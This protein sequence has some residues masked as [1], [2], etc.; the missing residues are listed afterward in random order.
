MN[1]CFFQKGL[2]QINFQT[3]KEDFEKMSSN[4]NEI[5]NNV[6]SIN[7]V[8][9]LYLKQEKDEFSKVLLD[10]EVDIEFFLKNLEYLGKKSFE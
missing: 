2:A 8:E 1:K 5:L 9:E 3:I 4:E 10:I 7:N 6:K